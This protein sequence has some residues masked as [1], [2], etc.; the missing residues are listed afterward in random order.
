MSYERSMYIHF[1]VRRMH[2][3]GHADAWRQR[4]LR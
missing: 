2:G 1:E 4:G 3:L